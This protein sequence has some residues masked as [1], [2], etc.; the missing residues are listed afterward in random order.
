[1]VFLL[2]AMALPQD[3]VSADP[4]PGMLPNGVG[5]DEVAISAI[6]DASVQRCVH[7]FEQELAP[8]AGMRID[9]RAMTSSPNLGQIWRADAVSISKP[10]RASRFVCTNA[11]KSIEPLDAAGAE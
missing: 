5:A 9:R 4:V 11:G 3:R 2:T 6:T 7:F 8:Q 1:M 10:V